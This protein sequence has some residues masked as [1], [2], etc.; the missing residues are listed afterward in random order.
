MPLTRIRQTAIGND[1]ITSAKLA[2]DLDLDG[3]FVRVPHGTT[4]Q[5][6]SSPAAGYMRFNTDQG[7]L[8]QWNTTTNSWQAIDSPP[9][10]TSLAYSGSLTAADPAGSETITLTGINFKSGATVTI[11]GTSATSVS[12]VS[13]TTITFTT[14]VKI[15]GDYDVVVINTNGLQ[16]T[17]LNGISYNGLPAFT[18]AAGNVGSIAED[19]A[20]ST[21]T[22]VAAEPDGGTLAYSITSGAL[23]TGVSMSSAGAITGTPNVNVTSDTTYNF[24]VTATDDENQTNAR[25]FNLIV[26]RP[27]YATSIDNS[28][29][30]SS[31]RSAMLQRTPSSD[32]NRKTLTWSGW[33]KRS[34]LG[35][36]QNLFTAEG[37]G[38]GESAAIRFD[39]SDRLDVMFL[40]DGSDSVTGRLITDAKFRDESAWLHIVYAQDTTSSTAGNRMRLY[41]NGSEITS[42]ATD[43]NP[44]QNHDGQFNAAVIHRLGAESHAGNQELDGYLSD[45]YLIDGQ[46]LTPTSFAEEYYG[47]WAPIPAY[48]GSYGTNGFHLEF[49]DSSAIGDDTSGNTNDWTPNNL[50]S[51]DVVPDSPTN[52]FAVMSN[53][54]TNTGSHLPTSGNLKLP[55]ANNKGMASTFAVNSGKWYWEIKINNEG[56]S[57][58]YMGA[59]ERHFV[60]DPD[61]QGLNGNH[62]SF[63]NYGSTNQVTNFTASSAT[64][65]GSGAEYGIAG[66]E[67]D[68]DGGTLKY[69][70]NGS[71]IHTDST[72]PTDGRHIAVYHGKTFSGVTDGWNSTTY[73]FGQN[74]TF[75]GT[76][77]A[78]GNADDN[79]VGDFKYAPSSGYLALSTKNFGEGAVAVNTDDRPEDYFNLAKYDGNGTTNNITLG[80]QPDF[81]WLKRTDGAGNH[82]LLDSLRGINRIFTSSNS[83]QL[84]GGD[85]FAAFNSTGFNLDGTGG[86]GDVNTSGRSY[87]GYG[88]KAGGAPTATNSA[89]V[90]NVPTSGSV[91]IDGVASTSALAGTIAA[92]KL[93][94]NTKAGF[95]IIKYTANGSSSQTVAHGLTQTPDLVMVKNTQSTNNWVLWTPDL[96]SEHT[97]YPNLT[98]AMNS[99]PSTWYAG[100]ITSTTIGFDSAEANPSGGSPVA[101][102]WH[103]VEGF[104]KFGTYTGTADANGP[105]VY[106]GFKPAYIMVRRYSTTGNWFVLDNKRN[107]SNGSDGVRLYWDGTGG[108][109]TDSGAYS[110]D[111][112]ANGFKLR[113]S[114]NVNASGTYLYMC[115]AEDPFKYAEA[116]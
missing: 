95:S 9:I 98:N 1:S 8:E 60:Y 92:D 74:G 28:L 86:G 7:T 110:I 29:R 77:T 57:A 66:Y 69:Y 63:A 55:K 99:S 48:S 105:T 64:N 16:A 15:A 4:A 107:P 2:H 73:N 5:R 41:V 22:I 102:C 21:I 10:I 71:L 19:T 114:S 106:T 89:G 109:S 12:V 37:D 54:T 87:I 90:G 6:P 72:I 70:F 75:D 3:D 78:G 17:L 53:L 36:F 26:L 115:F 100:G 31:D 93:S 34:K 27:I 11:G 39:S 59:S 30:F 38:G 83:Q 43:T 56:G 81:V 91:M 32:S 35:A 68:M 96:S 101:Y 65:A 85:G 20:M 103:S 51:D 45:V 79:G 49:G 25:A 50:N 14:P 113:S 18:T 44:T 62:T 111:F 23:P 47:V 88:W 67:L 33:V 61:S 104:S 116:R 42:F 46:A 97:L 52:N 58:P 112:L 13:S 80:F 94:A 108:D 24:T 84:S 76:E 40:T 82:V